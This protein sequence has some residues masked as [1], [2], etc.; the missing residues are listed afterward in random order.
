MAQFLRTQWGQVA[1]FGPALNEQAGH[2]PRCVAQ[3]AQR[4]S[5]VLDCREARVWL[6]LATQPS[7]SMTTD[8][9]TLACVPPMRLA[10]PMPAAEVWLTNVRT[11]PAAKA[12]IS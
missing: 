6:V 10:R 4:A 12:T 7:C 8:A 5:P 3:N 9:L 1:V 11:S 2:R